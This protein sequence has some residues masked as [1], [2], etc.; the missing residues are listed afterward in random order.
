M[1]KVY[2]IFKNF[3][4]IYHFAAR[5]KNVFVLID[6]TLIILKE[7]YPNRSKSVQLSPFIDLVLPTNTLSNIFYCSF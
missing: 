7:I 1:A 6:G 3:D 5:F 4:P 2:K